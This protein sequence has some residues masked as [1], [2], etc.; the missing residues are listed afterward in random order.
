MTARP[1]IRWQ[2]PLAFGIVFTLLNV[3]ELAF[4]D[5][6]WP[7]IVGLALGLVLVGLGVAR[8]RGSAGVAR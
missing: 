7:Q 4:L 5:G 3:V 1:W 6:G 2:V 8:G